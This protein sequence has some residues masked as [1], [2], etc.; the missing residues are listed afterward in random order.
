MT[1]RKPSFLFPRSI[2]TLQTLCVSSSFSFQKRILQRASFDKKCSRKK[3]LQF[4]NFL[5]LVIREMDPVMA[6]FSRL[7]H[8][9]VTLA[10]KPLKMVVCSCE[11]S[12]PPCIC[13]GSFVCVRVPQPSDD[14]DDPLNWSSA[15][16]HLLLFTISAAAF[17]PDYGTS[18]G[19]VTLI[20]QATEWHVTQDGMLRSLVGSLFMAGAAGI[21]VV[22]FMA[23]FGRLPIL[24]WF[25]IMSLWTAILCAAAPDLNTFIAARVVS[26]TFSTV[27]QASGLIFISD[28][29]FLHEYARKINIWSFA[30]ILSPYLGPLITAFIISKYSWRW[31]FWLNVLI[32]GICLLL[33]IVWGEE[34]YYERKAVEP[35]PQRKSWILRLL[36]T[37]QWRTRKQRNPSFMDAVR[38]ALVIL[39]PVV[40]ISCVY[41]LLIFSWVIGQSF[42][43]RLCLKQS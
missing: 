36:G 18:I 27:T 11:R 5:L 24:F 12:L 17:L 26:G 7:M 6:V 35:R 34:T 8:Q 14:P 32:T 28:L 2:Y 9:K 30:I 1:C 29:F 21:F 37:E 23:Y 42:K 22:V 20:P 4:V 40:F 33:T 31:S 19:A 10:L 43:P 13:N 15:K 38:P 3:T 16:K 25:L 39:Q 41:Y